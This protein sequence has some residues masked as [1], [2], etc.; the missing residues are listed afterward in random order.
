MSARA[1]DSRCPS[2]VR[3]RVRHGRPSHLSKPRTSAVDLKFLQ[4]A[5]RSYRCSKPCG[6]AAM[7]AVIIRVL[8]MQKGQHG[9]WIGSSSGSG[10]VV[11]G[12][13]KK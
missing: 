7:A 8:Q 3:I 4:S 9:R 10:F 6:P 11:A 12:I 1:E 2:Q 5:E 13:Q